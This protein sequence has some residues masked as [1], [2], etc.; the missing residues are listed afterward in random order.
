MAKG[1]LGQAF[2][3]D[4]AETLVFTVTSGHQVIISTINVC[5][6]T[7][8][9]QKFRIRIVK[10]PDGSSLDKQWLYYD[11][12][13]QG[14]DTFERT[15]AITLGAGDSVYVRTDL[16]NTLAFQFFGDDS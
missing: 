12:D 13:V 10:S 15:S 4:T 11:S 2:P 14:Y 8:N 7:A 16:G 1:I 6:K 9:L 5:N 3:A